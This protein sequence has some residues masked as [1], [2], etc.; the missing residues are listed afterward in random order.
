MDKNQSPEEGG[1]LYITEW[2]SGGSRQQQIKKEEE[3][4]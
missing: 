2:F 1:L 4:E 3:V